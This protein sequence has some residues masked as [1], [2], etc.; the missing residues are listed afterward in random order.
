VTLQVRER[1]REREREKKKRKR[2][3]KSKM[4]N[5]E[6]LVFNGLFDI[7]Q[8]ISLIVVEREMPGFQTL[9][10]LKKIGFHG[11]DVC[12]LRFENVQVPLT[13]LLGE[14][15]KG[16][17]YLMDNLVQERLSV[18]CSAVVGAEVALETTVQYCKRRRAFGKPIGQFQYNAF[19]LAE[20]K[21]EVRLF[22]SLTNIP[23]K[24]LKKTHKYYRFK[25][26][27]FLWID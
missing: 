13:N 5:F 6:K 22:F 20:M 10:I 23:T 3:R 11:R 24:N 17:H 19:K 1:E 7:Y 12:Y 26:L 8:G 18:S 14:E 25:S 15:G 27:V 21:T 4:S 16:F 2:K 9:K